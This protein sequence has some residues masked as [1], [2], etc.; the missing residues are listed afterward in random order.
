MTKHEAKD[1]P[2]I[3]VIGTGGTI[4]SAAASADDFHNYSVTSTAKEIL[5]AVPQIAE[6]ARIDIQQP[7]NI[8]SFRIDNAILLDIARAVASAVQDPQV[9]AAIVTHGTDT[10]EET[11]YFLNL[12]VSTD[13][14]VVIVGAMRPAN[15]LSADGP[16]NLY[17][18]ILTATAPE[19]AGK[20]VLVVANGHVFGAR[21]VVKRDT[22]SV[23]A[24]QANKY[25]ILAEI[26]GKS[27][28]FL[29][30]SERLHTRRSAFDIARLDRL[31][32]VDILF[33][34]PGAGSYLCEACVA[35]GSKALVVAGMGNGSLSPGMRKGATVA[36]NAGVTVIRASRTGQG[37]VAPLRSDAELGLLVAGKMTRQKT[38]ILA[39]VSIANE[40]PH[41]DL[42]ALFDTY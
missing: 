7:I 9:D 37:I 5:A 11:A 34:H 8:E 10:L 36:R 3:T 28:Q 38:R 18:A 25:G 41:E 27:V 16:L 2:R 35:A 32:Q 23:D 42:Q 13:K 29:H 17:N 15:A 26:S 33:D 1:L 12:V 39:A 20:G 14:P 19:S 24:F 4:A 21:D 30:R 31:P 6:L 22:S 40:I